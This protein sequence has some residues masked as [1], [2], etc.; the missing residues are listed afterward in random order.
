MHRISALGFNMHWMQWPRSKVHRQYAFMF[1]F[2]FF[3]S[4][5]HFV[6][7]I[8][9]EEREGQHLNVKNCIVPCYLTN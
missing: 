2:F 9:I 1:C 4:E 5:G 3:F 8:K 6:V 7:A